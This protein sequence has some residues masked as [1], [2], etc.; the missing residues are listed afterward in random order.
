MPILNYTTSVSVDKSALEIQKRLVTHKASHI[1]S[2][3]DAFGNLSHIAFRINTPQG[4]LAYKLPVNVDGVYRALFPKD[5][6][7]TVER[8]AQAA[9]VAWRIVKDWIEAQL[10]I[11][12]A[13]MAVIPQVFLPYAVTRDGSTVY[14]QFERG[15]MPLFLT[16][17]RK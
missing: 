6:K 9:R 13:Q 16:D 14:E 12:E 8:R 4:V 17:E 7:Q 15:D 3:Y 5:K 11:V 1:M 10:A 2:E